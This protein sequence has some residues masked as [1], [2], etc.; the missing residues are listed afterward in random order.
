M[1]EENLSNIIVVKRSGKRVN[2]DGTKIA[3]AIKKGFDSIEGKY[4][5]DDANKVYSKVIKAI[6]DDNLDKIKI[7]KIQDII[8]D[9]LK[10]SK[11][12]DVY[13]SFTEYREKRN[14]SREIFFEERRKHKFLKALEKLGL[15]S[16]GEI[17]Q[18][19]KNSLESMIDY[20]KAVSEEFATS[21]LIKKK[22]NL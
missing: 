17:I 2:F 6:Q 9:Q 1:N 21:Y 8:E 18:N 20:G 10:L 15:N 3:L 19:D 4:N 14:Q 5:E 16:K 22:A 13:K 7:E 11:Y 12:E